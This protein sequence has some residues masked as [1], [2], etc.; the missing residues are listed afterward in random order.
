MKKGS[1][2]MTSLMKITEYR[3]HRFLKGS[4]PDLRTLKRLIDDGELAGKRLGK[5]Y[6]IEIDQQLNEFTPLEKELMNHG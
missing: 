5:I 3:Q 2:I 1:L 4:E 6:Y